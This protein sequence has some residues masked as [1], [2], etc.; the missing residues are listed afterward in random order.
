MSNL[1]FFS[2]GVPTY[3]RSALLRRAL[4]HLLDQTFTDFELLIGDNCSTDDTQQWVQAL[5]D[6]RIRYFRHSVNLGAMPNFIFL[7]Q[8][9]K[10]QF[11][12]INQ[13]DDFLHREFLQHCHDTVIQDN[14][15][16]LYATPWWRGNVSNGF[17]SR[18]PQ[19]I[20][21]DG[22]EFAL[23]DR[24]V[25]VD[26]KK[27]AVSLLHSFYFAHPTLAFRRSTLEAVGGY[28]PEVNNVSDVI[29]EARV[30]SRGK[31]AYDPRMGGVF[32]DHGQNASRTMNKEFKITTYRNMYCGLITDLEK[33]GVDWRS[34]LTRDL[35]T[36]PENELLRIFSDWARYR[37]PA[38]LQAMGWKFL[39][40]HRTL[41]G[42]R[43]VRKLL[44]KV[45]FRNCMRFAKT[46]LVGR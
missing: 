10:G 2:I 39:R 40:N 20:H 32:T 26:G 28:H 23:Q 38:E 25:I 9:A 34:Q 27:A 43:L 24:A 35:G 12:V 4:A 15:I 44:H 19:N 8:Q 31:L 11:L 14:D 13:D 17:Q 36:Y 41:R 18:L 46:Q 33:S 3:N 7:T 16:V 5:K 6:S 22:P 29:T 45:G 1:P 30:L 37:A 21:P 42:G